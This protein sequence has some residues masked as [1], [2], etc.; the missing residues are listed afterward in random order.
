MPTSNTKKPVAGAT[1]KGPTASARSAA[2]LPTQGTELLSSRRVVRALDHLNS[3]KLT[4]ETVLW[5]SR[6][7]A[8]TR[9]H[10]ELVQARQHISDIS[11]LLAV[12]RL[13]PHLFGRLV[14]PNGDHAAFLQ[15]TAVIGLSAT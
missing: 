1:R 7:H 3:Q 9:F 12:R 8:V 15:L 5:N 6:I 13:P 4:D 2:A 11:R 14:Q 10:L